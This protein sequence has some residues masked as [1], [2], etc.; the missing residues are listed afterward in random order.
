MNPP[1]QAWRGRHVGNR[2]SPQGGAFVSNVPLY[3]LK[4][5]AERLWIVDGPERKSGCLGARL[6]FPTRMTVARLANGDLWLH[7]PLKPTET[8]VRD[9]D[10]LGRVRFL[11]APNSLHYWWLPEWQALFP[12]AQAFGAPSLGYCAKRGGFLQHVLSDVAPSVWAMEI[13]HVV[14]RGARLTE[15][16]FFH[17]SSKTLILTDL[18]EN[19]EIEKVRPWWLR[20]LL[21][22]SRALDRADKAP[23]DMRLRFARGHSTVRQA[24]ERMIAWDPERLIIAHGRW[25]P[26]GAVTELKRAFRWVLRT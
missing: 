1:G 2:P 4:P 16:G 19:F 20:V 3:A 25:Y 24:V 11:I 12:R 15:V 14:V 18:I 9:L 22:A 7:C 6:P 21:R 26:I 17:H 23:I 13:G 8:L 5:V 10:R